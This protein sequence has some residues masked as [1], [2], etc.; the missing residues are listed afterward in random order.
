MQV[1]RSA[2]A[3]PGLQLGFGALLMLAIK[4][5]RSSAAIS[6]DAAAAAL[7]LSATAIGASS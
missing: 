2:Q 3:R 5:L 6:C 4:N 1:L 7:I